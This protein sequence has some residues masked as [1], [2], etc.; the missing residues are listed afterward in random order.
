M[1]KNTKNTRPVVL[2]TG[3]SSGLGKSYAKHYAEIDHDL[4]LVARREKLLK[5]IAS[6]LSK[7]YGCS[8]TCIKQDLST[9]NSAQKLFSKIKLKKIV[10]DIVINNAGFGKWAP[11]LDT[12]EKV[13]TQ[14]MLLNMNTLSDMCYLFGNAMKKRKSGTIINIASVAGFVPGPFASLYFATKAFVLSLSQGLHQELKK[15]GI[16]VM[17]VCPGPTKTEFFDVAASKQ[18]R[19]S[20][21]SSNLMEV[22]QVVKGTLK[23]CKSKKVVYIPGFINNLV[24]LAPLTPLPRKKMLALMEKNLS[25]M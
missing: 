21:E 12:N 4:I 16:H 20:D 1:K 19:L 25:R 15:H 13:N 2:I 5:E 8:I 7:R 17:A 9:P 18:K 22:E 11:F 6:D 10:P 14:M 23:A 24:Q 3:A